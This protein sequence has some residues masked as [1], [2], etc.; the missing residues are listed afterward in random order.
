MY[1]GIDTQ[2]DRGNGLETEMCIVPALPFRSPSFI[3]FILLL[4]FVI[5]SC[6]IDKA[7]LKLSVLI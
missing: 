2:G 7:G 3:L 1:N 6:Y 4:V 5:L